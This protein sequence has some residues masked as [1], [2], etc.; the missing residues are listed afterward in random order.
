MHPVIRD[1]YV[2]ARVTPE[3]KRRLLAA[4]ARRGLTVS[5]LIRDA[6]GR[7]SGGQKWPH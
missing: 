1:T 5:A 7:A 3:E 2:R 4:A 6:V